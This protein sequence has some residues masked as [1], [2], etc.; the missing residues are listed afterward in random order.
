MKASLYIE[1][2]DF[3]TFFVWVNRLSQGVLSTCPVKYSQS[4]EGI[5]DPV[6]LLLDANEYAMLR[7][8]QEDIED[9]RQK[10][11]DNEIIFYPEPLENEKILIGS[12]LR[13]AQRHDLEVDLVNT[14]L[15][16]S[17]RIPGITPLEAMV[18]AERE[19][20]NVGKVV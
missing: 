9:L 20:I 8:A 17:T 10:L 13:N 5:A 16:L 12:I 6:H 15:E 1:K 2:P 11:G 4:S 7:D 19:W 18:I 14:A 3:D